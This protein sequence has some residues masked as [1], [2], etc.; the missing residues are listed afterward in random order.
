MYFIAIQVNS[1]QKKIQIAQ[2]SMEVAI[3]NICKNVRVK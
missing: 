2:E 1:P 3:L